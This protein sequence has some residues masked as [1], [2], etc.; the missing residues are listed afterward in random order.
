[1]IEVFAMYNPYIKNTRK[2]FGMDKSSRSQDYQK[3]TKSLLSYD[4]LTKTINPFLDKNGN[5]FNKYMNYQ[6]ILDNPNTSAKTKEFISQATGLSQTPVAPVQTE[7]STEGT[8]AKQPSES[9]GYG[10]NGRIGF[11][12]GK[13]ESGGYNGGSISSGRGDHGGISY[14]V[15]QFST[16]T[17]SA[18]SFVAWLKKS[19]PQ[20]GQAFGN[21][22]A[23]TT[24]FSNAWKKVYSDFGDKFSDV[25]SQYAYD[26]FAKPLADL[27][28]QKTGIDYNR[29]TALRELLYSTAVQFGSGSLGLSALGNVSANMSD[30]DIINASYDKKIANYKNYFKSSGQTVQESVKNRFINERKDVLALVGNSGNT[31]GGGNV[32]SNQ[33]SKT[34]SF[35]PGVKIAN[36]NNYHNSAATGQ[37][38]WYVRGRASEKLGK[39]TGAIGNG[40][41]MWYNAKPA[42]KLS[43]TADNIKPNII[44][45]YKNGVSSAGKKY[46]HVIFIEDVVGDT[47]YYTEGGSGYHKNGTDGVVKTA[48]R[49]GILNGVNSNGSRM[50]SGVIGFIDLSKY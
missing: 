28:K 23:G 27:A 3:K 44:V 50:G 15:P 22:R 39:D 14:G 18:D 2:I 13:Y 32:Q 12:S 30:A 1:M 43:A 4:D 49:Q 48:T 34:T 29:S 21:S 47:V 6:A 41:Q 5:V 36:T 31:S 25:Q 45:S 24:E 8:A 17:G 40:N 20:M 26:N 46:G 9:T 42:A 19:N 35:K 16:T 38:V 33:S 37:C 7:D 10:N 11:I